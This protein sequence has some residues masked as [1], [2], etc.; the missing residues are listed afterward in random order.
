MSIFG[1][2]EQ[3]ANR[4][5]NRLLRKPFPAVGRLLQQFAD[6]HCAH[7]SRSQTRRPSLHAAPLETVHL[8]YRSGWFSLQRGESAASI[9]PASRALVR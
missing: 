4:E 9:A 8:T 7:R 2:D 6:E 5:R 3:A 1:R